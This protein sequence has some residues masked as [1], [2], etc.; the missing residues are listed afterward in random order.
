MARDDLCVVLTETHN[1]TTNVPRYTGKARPHVLMTTEGTYPHYTGGVS[2]WCDLLVREL[3]EV[4][5]TIWALMMNP[6][7]KQ[8][9]E[10]PA[11]VKQFVAVPLWGIEQPAEYTREL[12]TAQVFRASRRTRERDV[13]Q[14]FLPIFDAFVNTVSSPI[15]DAP[16]FARTLVAMHDYFREW[17]YRTTWRSQPVWEAYRA[18]S[19]GRLAGA[20]Y[21]RP[22]F[23]E[24]EPVLPNA[25]GIADN[26]KFLVRGEI[27]AQ[28]YEGLAN[29]Q[30]DEVPTVA[31][32]IEGLRMLYRLMQPL[33]F[34]VPETDV[35]H[36]AA[37]A[38]CALPCLLAKLERNTPFLLTEHGVYLR[39]QY[40]AIERRRV[41]Y[42]LKR[43]LINLISSIAQTSY[44]LADQVSPVCAFN[45]RWEYAYG[46]PQE[47]LK[48]IYNGVD[49]EV[50]Q[51]QTVERLSA[52]TVVQVGRI[53]PLKDQV[54]FL[55]VAAA[56]H[57]EMPE[58]RFVH[59]GPVAD[60]EYGDTVAELHKELGLED[61]VD[62]RGATKNPA[63]AYAQGD[64]VLLT[65]ISE[66]FPYAV[67]ESL[68]CGKPVVSTAVG[69]V[70]EALDGGIGLT[71]PAHDVA[72]LAR[73]V[74]HYLRMNAAERAEIS[75]EARA[76]AIE[77]FTLQRFL[78][79][80]METYNRLA[81]TP[82]TIDLRPYEVETVDL[83]AEEAEREIVLDAEPE[84]V[85]EQPGAHAI[86]LDLDTIEDL[87][88]HLRGD[89]VFA[90]VEALRRVPALPGV[91]PFLIEAAHDPTAVVRIQAVLALGRIGG[92]Q[93]LAA[94][95]E[96]MGTD[97]ASEVREAAVS[98]LLDRAAAG[99]AGVGVTA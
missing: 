99:E 47:R 67:V 19:I 63:G 10:F 54:T 49:Q 25:R 68:M 6:F 95:T 7:V 43:F 42:N 3:G 81:T 71:A 45:S 62:F 93:A 23:E 2:T 56:V 29:V 40:L 37:A 15:F 80:H 39:E 52:P 13:E 55:R 48:V 98:A 51:P 26:I 33:N 34:E 90:K 59:Y 82:A 8:Q 97:P 30:E 96:L 27:Q 4:D 84:I 60:D 32:A 53:D 61:V 72:G 35:T 65:S 73:A 36:S 70:H 83:E 5:F 12:P 79:N 9:F 94:I 50:F 88:H 85:L 75:T 57:Q 64:V 87:Q 76:H 69:G 17:D 89:D 28:R 18:L 16:A 86:P 74:L 14:H 92:P 22:P 78:D 91:E 41:P 24:D 1:T 66:A 46:V 58:V 11:N 21:V 44:V 20:T 31:E 77:N 38:F